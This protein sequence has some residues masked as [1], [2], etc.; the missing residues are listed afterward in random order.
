MNNF[1]WKKA[2]SNQ[3]SAAFA[4]SRSDVDSSALQNL[5]HRFRIA[6]RTLHWLN[7]EC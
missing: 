7:A 6:Q 2:V 5:N 4:F 1:Q 3:H